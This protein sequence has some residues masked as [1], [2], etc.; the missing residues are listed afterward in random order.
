MPVGWPWLEAELAQVRP[1]VL[2][3]LGATAAQAQ[4]GSAFRVS[5]LRGERVATLLAPH[6]LATVHP[7]SV[8]RAPDEAARREET[9]RFIADVRV[10]AE[11]LRASLDAP[12]S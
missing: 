7:S 11:L 3:C 1:K 5:R 6:A 4:L 2:L 8:L 9:A 12:S 10:A